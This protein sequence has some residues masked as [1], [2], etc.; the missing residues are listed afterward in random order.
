M[1]FSYDH[2]DGIEFHDTAEQAKARAE[3]ALDG[4]RDY[5]DDGWN[6]EVIWICWGEVK[7]RVCETSRRK[8]EPEEGK[9]YE[10]EVD[11]GLRDTDNTRS[12]RP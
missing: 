3:A 11:Y 12:D 9:D 5:A 8:V 4:D 10:E 7:Q 6:E 2:E 1:F